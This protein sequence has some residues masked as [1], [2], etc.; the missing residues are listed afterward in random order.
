MFGNSAALG[1]L[2]PIWP[3][4][5]ARAA[6]QHHEHAADEQCD[7]R[8]LLDRRQHRRSPIVCRINVDADPTNNDPAC[9]PLNRMGI[10]VANPAAIAYVLGDPYRD[11]TVTEKDGGFNLSFKPFSTW[12]GDVSVAVGA[13]YREERITRLRANPVPAGRHGG[14]ERARS[15]ANAWSVGNYL[16]TNGS[17]T[18]RKPISRRSCRWAS[19]SNS[20]A[21]CAP[22]IIR[23]RAMSRP[24]APARPGSRSRIS[25]SASRGRATS[26]RPTSTNCSRPAPRTATR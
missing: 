3:A 4:A 19:A 2:C 15:T 21:P 7:R 12:A 6:A 17:T 24:G 1:C 8:G 26:A 10:G 20:T 23:L 14:A 16:P 9:V 25:G 22:P 5:A 18:S 11:E 13:E